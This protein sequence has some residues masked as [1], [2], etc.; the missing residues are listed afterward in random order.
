MKNRRFLFEED[1]VPHALGVMALPLFMLTI[2]ISN[3]FGSGGGTLI[4]RLIGSG[5]LTEPSPL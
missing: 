3:V 4:S 5:D 1:S 2:V